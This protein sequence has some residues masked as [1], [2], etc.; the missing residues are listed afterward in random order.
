VLASTQGSPAPLP[1]QLGDAALALA[2]YMYGVN[3][4]TRNVQVIGG[5]LK[6]SV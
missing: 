1:K 2:D 3:Y 4:A 5:V 6:V